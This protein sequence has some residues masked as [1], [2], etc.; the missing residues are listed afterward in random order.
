[1]EQ[2]QINQNS[3]SMGSEQSQS[4]GFFA[5]LADFFDSIDRTIQNILNSEGFKLFKEVLIGVGKIILD[6]ANKTAKEAD[7]ILINMGWWIFP[8]WTPA[9]IFNVVSLYKEGKKKQI[10]MQIMTFFDNKKLN[11]ILKEWKQ[12][13]LL[14]SRI[15]ILKDA[16]WAHNKGKYTLSVPVLLPQL[17]GIMVEGLELK[18]K[19]RYKELRES[20]KDKLKAS[21]VDFIYTIKSSGYRIIEQY[22]SEKF[23]WGEPINLKVSRHAILHGHHTNY[24][25]KKTS[26]KLILLIDYVQKV[27]SNNFKIFAS[28]LPTIRYEPSSL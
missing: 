13:P 25:R 9:D 19:V 5:S 26:L 17:E 14:K 6:Y 12:N 18:G 1:M 16:I 3:L 8:D 23:E 21:E 7:I 15:H 10:E 27:M 28:S 20:F 4:K 24:N 11:K 22:I 2:K